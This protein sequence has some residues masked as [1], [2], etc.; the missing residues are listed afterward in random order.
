MITYNTKEVTELFGWSF[1]HSMRRSKRKNQLICIPFKKAGRG[2][3]RL[4]E[5]HDSQVMILKRYVELRDE[6]KS[7]RKKLATSHKVKTL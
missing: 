6:L 2:S 4:D 5:W 3:K 1:V 7:L